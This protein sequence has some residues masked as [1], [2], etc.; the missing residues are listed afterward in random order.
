MGNRPNFK[1][2]AASNSPRRRPKDINM[3][4]ER[5]DGISDQV[6]SLQRAFA[7]HR[8]EFAASLARLEAILQSR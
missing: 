3:S 6:D 7:N 4:E 2:F 5:L 8:G 1:T